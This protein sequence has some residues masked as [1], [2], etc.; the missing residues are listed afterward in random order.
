MFNQSLRRGATLERNPMGQSDLLEWH[1][2]ELRTVE[3]SAPTRLG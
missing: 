3:L 2:I 1:L